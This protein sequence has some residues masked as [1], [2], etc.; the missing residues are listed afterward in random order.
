M[1]DLVPFVIEKSAGGERSYDLYSRLLKDRVIMFTSEVNDHTASL[2]VAKLLFLE[3]EDPKKDITMYINSPGGSVTA[4]LSIFDTMQYISCDVSTIVV[5]QAASM[6]SIFAAAGAHGKRLMLP[7]SSMMIHQPSSGFSG[8]ASDIAI[9]AAETLHWKRKLTEIL[10]KLSYGKTSIK[11]MED[12]MDRDSY[13]R[14]EEAI[15]YGLI[16]KVISS[17]V[18]KK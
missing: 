13:M 2:A 12:L 8:T 18:V 16:D 11:E 3:S 7:N 10:S 15:E 17:R 14:P 9:Q 4:G 5:G 6:G 1:S